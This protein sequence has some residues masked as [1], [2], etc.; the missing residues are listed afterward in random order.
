MG[1]W[2]TVCLAA[3]A[4]ICTVA[5][6]NMFVRI[7]QILKCEEAGGFVVRTAEGPH[8]CVRT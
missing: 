2:F 7:Y 3:V 8:M 1:K 5:Q 4:V 6:L